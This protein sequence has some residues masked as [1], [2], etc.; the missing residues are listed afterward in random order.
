M[1]DKVSYFADKLCRNVFLLHVKRLEYEAERT[2]NLCAI[3]DEHGT[4]MSAGQR[5]IH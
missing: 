1:P 5:L 2:I 3:E 4:A